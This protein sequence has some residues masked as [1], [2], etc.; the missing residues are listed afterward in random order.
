M[1]DR[2]TDWTRMRIINGL[3]RYVYAAARSTGDDANE[4]SRQ[5]VEA[6]EWVKG[7]IR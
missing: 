4:A 7:L 2:A 5:A 6:A 3:M 1:P